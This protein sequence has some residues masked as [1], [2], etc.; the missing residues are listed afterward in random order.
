MSILIEGMEMPQDCND[1]K[2]VD[3]DPVRLCDFCAVLNADIE[4]SSTRLPNCPLEKVEPVK[5]GKWIR[6]NISEGVCSNCHSRF[7][8]IPYNNTY[9]FKPYNY[10]PNCGARMENE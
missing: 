7:W 5:T 8:G 2:L 1:C 6:P 10:C 9:L 3:Y 4:D